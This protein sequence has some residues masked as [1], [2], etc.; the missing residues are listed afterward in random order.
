MIETA[1]VLNV[2]IVVWLCIVVPGF[3]YA[4]RLVRRANRALHWLKANSLN[5][6]RE[7]VAR[8]AVYR[9]QIRVVIFACMVVMGLDAGAIQYF[10]P[11]G[12]MRQVL[13]GVFRLLFIL[14]AISFSYKS[15]LE[16]HELDLLV[17]EDQ[18]RSSRAQAY[19]VSDG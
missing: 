4:L 1:I 6:Y 16:D 2:L 12:D 3:I 10:P 14:M 11:G 13:S 8:G 17:S 18:R 9:G 19:E 5:G 7:I 15:W